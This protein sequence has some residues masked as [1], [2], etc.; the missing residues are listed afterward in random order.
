MKG[1]NG[2]YVHSVKLINFKSIGDYPESEII[3]EPRITTIIGKNES[4]KSNV[5]D[6]LSRIN[7]ISGFDSIFS[8]D[9][10]NRNCPTGTQMKFFITLK[11]IPEEEALGVSGITEIMV[12][13]G[14]YKA[15]GGLLSYYIQNVAP[16]VDSVVE[17]LDSIGTNPMKLKDQEVTNYRNHRSELLQKD[18][19]NTPRKAAAVLFMKNRKGN[20]PAE[21]QD[22]FLKAMEKAE[23]EWKRLS[24]MLPVF[25]YRKSDKHLKTRYSLEDVEKELKKAPASDSLLVDFVKLIGIS[26]DD[27]ISAVRSGS[28]STQVSL[29][30]RINGNVERE[31]NQK[32][33]DFYQTESISLLLDFN[34]NSVTF[35]VQS[36]DGE[37][38]LL[39]ERS[40]GLQ[41]YLETFID[42]KA[43]NISGQNVVYLLDEPGVSLHVNAQKEL[44][45]LFNHLAEKG[46]QIVYTTH[47]PYMLDLE[48]GVHRIRAVTKTAEG[49]TNIYKTAYDSRIA[50]ETQQDTL[51]PL[52]SALGMNLNDTF[53]PSKDK[54]NIVTEGMSDYI[55]IC[56]MAKAL[57]LDVNKYSIIPSVGASNCVNICAILHGWGC[58]YMAVFDYDKAGV[59]SGGEI[60]HRDMLCELGKQYC[61]LKN[62]TEEDL[63]NRTYSDDG[64]VIED[65]ITREEISRFCDSTST[66]HSLGKPLTAKLIA[67]AVDNGSFKLSQECID[68]FKNLFDRI[69]HG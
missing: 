34:T 46:N 67:N 58:R 29:R 48:D 66:S 52:I 4:G 26:E 40:N 21:N 39:S 45:H 49:Y 16:S 17:L 13:K 12:S 63:E 32:F 31:I 51:A 19:I 8:T 68:N 50:P 55:Y 65:L 60:L 59:E 43:H 10:L 7:L 14:Q 69:V 33:H 6:G 24:S 18:Y 2:M 3:L 47:S 37:A 36:S 64:C 28:S 9:L 42:A 56:M 38:L 35:S 15:T 57:C 30:R 11:P 23:Q 20:L 54:L 25:F 53:G 44:I 27:F 41:W 22:D 62:V 61:Y 1:V 5:L